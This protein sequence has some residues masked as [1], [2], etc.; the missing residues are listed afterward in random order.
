MPCVTVSKYTSMP[1]PVA[2]VVP[3]DDH[4]H[5]FPTWG[6]PSPRPWSWHELLV[7]LSHLPAGI[8]V[9]RRNPGDQ[10]QYKYVLLHSAQ[11]ELFQL[12]I[13][14]DFQ[15]GWVMATELGALLFH[16][17]PLDARQS[18]VMVWGLQQYVPN[19]VA[20]I[21]SHS[22]LKGLFNSVRQIL[23][24]RLPPQVTEQMT[25]ALF[26]ERTKATPIQRQLSA[27]R[28]FEE[29]LGNFA[30]Y[31]MLKLEPYTHDLPLPRWRQPFTIERNGS[32]YRIS[33][34][35]ALCPEFA[36]VMAN[37]NHCQLDAT[38]YSMKPYVACVPQFVYMNCS[39]PVGLILAPTESAELYDLFYEAVCRLYSLQFLPKDFKFQFDVLCD[40]GAGLKK[41][42]TDHGLCRFQCHRHLIEWFGNKSIL[43]AMVLKILRSPSIEDMS[44]NVAIANSV[45]LSLKAAGKLNEGTLKKYLTLTGQ[46]L[47]AN[48]RFYR[49]PDF[50]AQIREWALWLRGNITSCSN[51]AESFHRIMKAV[52]KPNGK[53][54]GLG[55]CLL[56]VLKAIYD[57]QS[58]FKESFTR[59][60]R[61]Y[62]RSDDG[63]VNW[64]YLKEVARRFQLEIPPELMVSPELSENMLL[65]R[66][67]QIGTEKMAQVEISKFPTLPRPE[68]GPWYGPSFPLE[69][70]HDRKLDTIDDIADANDP[71]LIVA[72]D[73]FA[74]LA[75][76]DRTQ[77][78]MLWVFHWTVQAL[79]ESAIDPVSQP[80]DAYLAA[81]GKVSQHLRLEGLG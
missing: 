12:G 22:I 33:A 23:A 68:F 60:I 41:F 29:F 42:C 26:N 5:P 30:G 74:V 62:R 53:H 39:Y 61:N 75:K 15:H 67:E 40:A 17:W 35:V 57:K 71:R 34:M 56:F 6:P 81:W 3:G 32:K 18:A 48:G 24:K 76:E 79:E 78:T 63:E 51:H 50:W 69:R 49:S 4:L 47:S 45:V 46:T 65:D 73:I 31:C 58:S 52:V 28:H 25:F 20:P 70:R 14:Q 1:V 7:L 27:Q 43:K 37:F 66:L 2:F 59:N 16:K 77:N 54:V 44:K 9:Q 8:T 19:M 11:M 36:S 64:Q 72:R 10:S 38:F 80:A 21:K 13:S 55:K